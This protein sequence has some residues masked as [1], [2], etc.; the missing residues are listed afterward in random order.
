MKL[1]LALQAF[2]L[3]YNLNTF[4][5]NSFL[6]IDYV[7]KSNTT[8]FWFLPFVQLPLVIFID[9]ASNAIFVAWY[10]KNKTLF[11]LIIFPH[12]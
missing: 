9:N 8:K 2:F 7:S 5:N 11:I 3:R 10:C 6:C 1:K 12:L 4:K